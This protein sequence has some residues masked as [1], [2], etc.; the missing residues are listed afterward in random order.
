MLMGP[1]AAI[2]AASVLSTPKVAQFVEAVAPGV[3]TAPAPCQG[4][5]VRLVTYAI[6][7]LCFVRPTL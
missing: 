2:S 3:H 6:I 4:F 7:R 5:A 1:A